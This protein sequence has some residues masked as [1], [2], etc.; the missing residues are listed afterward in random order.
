MGR[1]IQ[2]ECSNEDD[3]VDMVVGAHLEHTNSRICKLRDYDVDCVF[4]IQEGVGVI[5]GVA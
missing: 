3:G 1:K 2:T 4:D 5:M